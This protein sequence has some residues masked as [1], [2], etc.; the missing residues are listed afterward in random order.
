MRF[1]SA[2]AVFLSL[3][4][5]VSS[6]TEDGRV[7]G[8]VLD[9]SGTPVA[10]AT[11]FVGTLARGPSTQTDAKGRFTLEGVPAGSVGLHAFKTSDGHPYDMFAFFT[12]PGEKE[13]FVEITSGQTVENVVIQL[14]A[15]A[16]TLNLDITDENG[17]PIDAQA[18]FSRPDLGKVGNYERSVKSK[19]SLMVPPVPFRMT[20]EARGFEAWHYGG[21]RWESDEGLLRL[22]PEQNFTLSIKLR[23]NR[24]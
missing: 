24:P 20:V 8:I 17:A 1:M 15:R 6:Q 23:R 5:T 10:E 9:R 2:A 12:M 7:Q 4:S 21:S 13:P 19:D 22:K 18:S 16:A 11:V 3:T 14:G